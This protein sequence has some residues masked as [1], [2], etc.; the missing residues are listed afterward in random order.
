MTAVVVLITVLVGLL[1]GLTQGLGRESTSAVTGLRAEQLVFSGH[2]PSFAS[3]RVP[4]S[5]DIRGAPLGFATTRA[6][7]GDK[8]APVTAI[9]LVPGS[10]IAPDATGVAHGS[11]V[12]AHKAATSLGVRAGGTVRVGSHDF[13]VAAVRGDASFSHVPAIWMDLRD[14]QT[15]TGAGDTATVVATSQET[16]VPHGYTAVPLA[17]SAHGEHGAG[18]A[19]NVEDQPPSTP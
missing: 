8:I 2:T 9:G 15:T 3:P 5:A 14:W 13:V 12:L 1:S 19:E 4:A 16:T 10:S 18:D 6:A 11:V 17:K 7:S